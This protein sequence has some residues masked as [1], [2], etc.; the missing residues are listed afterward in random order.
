MDLHQKTKDLETTI[1]IA[2]TFDLIDNAL[3]NIGEYENAL[4]AN[5]KK[6]ASFNEEI[7]KMIL[8]KVYTFSQDGREAYREI[9][10]L[11]E[12]K[13]EK[14]ELLRQIRQ[15]KQDK[16]D[17]LPDGIDK[18]YLNKAIKYVMLSCSQL[19]EA[20]TA[21]AELQE[22]IK[23]LKDEKKKYIATN[24]NAKKDIE[25]IAVRITTSRKDTVI[26]RLCDDLEKK[27]RAYQSLPGP[28]DKLVLGIAVEN[29]QSYRK[30]DILRQKLNDFL[31]YID[32][33]Q[34][35]QREDV[36]NLE[37]MLED[38]KSYG[39]GFKEIGIAYPD[40]QFAP[41]IDTR[42][43]M[44]EIIRN[45]LNF[46]QEVMVQEENTQTSQSSSASIPEDQ[47]NQTLAFHQQTKNPGQ[48]IRDKLVSQEIGNDIPII[49][50]LMHGTVIYNDDAR[51]QPHLLGLDVLY[52]LISAAPF[53]TNQGKKMN[54][55]ILELLKSTKLRRKTTTI[56]DAFEEAETIIH[57]PLSFDGTRFMLFDQQ[58]RYDAAV[59][60]DKRNHFIIN[61]K[62]T[63][64]C[65]KFWQLEEN[66]LDMKSKMGI[67]VVNKVRDFP[68]GLNL[69][70]H[71]E[72]VVYTKS[73][74]AAVKYEIRNGKECVNKILSMFFYKYLES[75]GFQQVI[76]ID[77]SCEVPYIT[78]P[79]FSLRP[80]NNQDIINDI[81][82]L[83]DFKN[84]HYQCKTENL[85]A[86]L[87]HKKFLR[88]PH[89]KTNHTN[90]VIAQN[91]AKNKSRKSKF[92]VVN[93]PNKKTR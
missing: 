73:N 71:K 86:R 38:I 5:E 60:K 34:K 88:N 9:N 62:G 13:L 46:E 27:I 24:Q 75:K 93:G 50:V 56:K 54:P 31:K 10:A 32:S 35:L 72:F 19:I 64:V 36:A 37:I 25:A 83:T 51:C 70:E 53:E 63:P 45:E 11:V 79:A 1:D 21:D 77:G 76:L 66:D 82:Y 90:A 85:L 14:D 57:E 29:Q 15:L 87:Y 42:K 67:F 58:T 78:N 84:F 12:R 81:K 68:A 91:R 43:R 26:S 8:D 41:L 17:I 89:Y 55:K 92:S 7:Q 49:V 48:K 59:D 47:T 33:K 80:K 40:T 20:E 16:V 6:I 18:E 39:E 23:K 52:R 61:Y 22:L 44:L 28:K 4:Y 74:A 65:R 30:Q 2:L 3:D 69:L